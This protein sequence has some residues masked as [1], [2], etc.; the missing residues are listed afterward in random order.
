[1]NIL[2]KDHTSTNWRDFDYCKKKSKKNFLGKL[3]HHDTIEKKKR[4]R[5]RCTF[6]VRSS[7]AK[8]NITCEKCKRHVCENHAIN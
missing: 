3:L 6:C 2:E 5:G 4:K 1:M 7:D 8:T